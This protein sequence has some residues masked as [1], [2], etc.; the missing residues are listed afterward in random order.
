MSCQACAERRKKARDALMSAKIAEAAGHIAKGTAEMLGIKAKSGHKT[1]VK[2][3]NG[4][5]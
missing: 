1:K 3:K 2:P 4:H 5:N